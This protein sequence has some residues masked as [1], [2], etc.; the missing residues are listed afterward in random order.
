MLGPKYFVRLSDPRR[1]R[2]K[3]SKTENRSRWKWLTAETSLMYSTQR[4]VLYMS[5]LFE[6]CRCVCE[7]AATAVISGEYPHISP[8]H[9]VCKWA[10]AVGLRMYDRA[11]QALLVISIIQQSPVLS[12][13]CQPAR[14]RWKPAAVCGDCSSVWRLGEK[15]DES[16]PRHIHLCLSPA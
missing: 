15:Y 16:Y 12:D 3:W 6:A 13:I 10:S 14:R 5:S 1:W 2:V 8:V 9:I 7:P 11:P 4:S